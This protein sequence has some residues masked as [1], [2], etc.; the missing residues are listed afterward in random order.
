M[1]NANL[2]VPDKIPFW[3]I[4]NEA[5][6]LGSPVERTSLTMGP[7]ERFDVI[8]DFT[9]KQQCSLICHPNVHR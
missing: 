1:D 4:G 8:L 9:S 3:V 7:A 5:G 2:P 6:F